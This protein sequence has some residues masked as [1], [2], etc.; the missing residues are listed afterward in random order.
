[1]KSIHDYHHI[2]A[3]IDGSNEAQA[4]LQTAIE[5]VQQDSTRQLYI[6]HVVDEDDLN[7]FDPNI[8]QVKRDAQ[9]A[10]LQLLQQAHHLATQAGLTQITI[11]SELG[12]PKAIIAHTIPE[13]YHIDL[14]V[15][16]ST[17]TNAVERLLQGSTTEFVSRTSN[18]NTLIIHDN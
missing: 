12:N 2:L 16:G 17:G 10:S 4:A 5:I 6:V 1:M 18:V 7:L 13:H 3:P 8:E 15:M 11:R 9:Q 14:I